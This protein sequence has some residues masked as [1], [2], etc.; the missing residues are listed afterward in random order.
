MAELKRIRTYDRRQILDAIYQNLE[1]EPLLQT[2]NRK[3]LRAVQPGFEYV[4]PLW[5]LRVGE[6]RVYYDATEQ[7]PVVHVRAVRRKEPG[8]TSEA[9]TR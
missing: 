7:P 4:P 1:H 5:E 6:Y 3:P 9:I 2:N 8:Q